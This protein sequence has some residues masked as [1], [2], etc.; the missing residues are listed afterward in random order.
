[1]ALGELETAIT[2]ERI[3]MPIN[4]ARAVEAVVTLDFAELFIARGS[5]FY[6]IAAFSIPHISPVL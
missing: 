3:A 6:F 2:M 5:S 1:M 4:A